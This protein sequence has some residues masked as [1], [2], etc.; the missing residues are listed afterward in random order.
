M[1]IFVELEAPTTNSTS[2]YEFVQ[3]FAGVMRTNVTAEVG[4]KP[5]DGSFVMGCLAHTEN[6][7]FST[8]GTLIKGYSVA[9]AFNA[10]YTGSGDAPTR[11]MDSCSPVPCNPSCPATVGV[12]V[13]EAL[14]FVAHAA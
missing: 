4:A 10:W 12:A 11:L 8:S 1:Q 7:A 14:G 5:T 6:T 13:E 3:Y 2:V 9:Q